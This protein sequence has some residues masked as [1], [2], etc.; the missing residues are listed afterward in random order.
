MFYLTCL[1][2]KLKG[3]DHVEH[4]DI[5]CTVILFKIPVHK[6]VSD[7]AGLVGLLR[8]YPTIE[9][10]SEHSVGLRWRVIIEIGKKKYKSYTPSNSV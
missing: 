1:S 5:I 10:I 3:Q 2:V 6:S 8:L 9:K 4:L 7:G